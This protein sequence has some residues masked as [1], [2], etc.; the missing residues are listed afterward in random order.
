MQ[1]SIVFTIQYA[2]TL[3]LFALNCISDREPRDKVR[4]STNTILR[5][6]LYTGECR[7]QEAVYDTLEKPSPEIS[8][9]FV[10]ILFFEWLT[11]L[12]WWGFRRPVKH[13]NLWDLDPKMM[14]HGIVPM[15]ERELEAD[16]KKAKGKNRKKGADGEEPPVS[17][18]P[19]MIRAFGWN[20]F[21]ASLF[22]VMADTLSLA[23]PQ[24]K[25]K[26]SWP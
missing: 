2:C 1:A 22:K 25:N 23:S 3:A 26:I 24:V 12:L 19:V 10:S 4:N 8:A 13:E 16:F 6:R 7:S 18:L 21:L 9:P 20:Y 17:L 5:F 14:S 11:P 15:F